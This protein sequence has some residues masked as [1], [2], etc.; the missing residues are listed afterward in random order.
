MTRA[1]H[2]GGCTRRPRDRVDPRDVWFIT[3][4]VVP[5]ARGGSPLLSPSYRDSKRVIDGGD[6]WRNPQSGGC[7]GR[8]QRKRRDIA[9]RKSEERHVGRRSG[10]GASG[11]R[12]AR[13]LFMQL[14]VFT[15][16]TD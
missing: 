10:A 9:L 1:T 6:A 3:P 8:D 7:A 4:L 12:S 14:H 5:P 16:C 13:R 2:T 15:S 11:Q